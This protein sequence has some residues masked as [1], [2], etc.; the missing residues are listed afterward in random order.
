MLNFNSKSLKEVIGTL[1]YGPKSS[2]EHFPS[3]KNT[4]QTLAGSVTQYLKNLEIFFLS[5]AYRFF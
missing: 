1:N 5:L 3:I 4:E 2:F